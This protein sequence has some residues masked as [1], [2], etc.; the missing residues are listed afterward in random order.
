M[1]ASDPSSLLAQLTA[2]LAEGKLLV[3]TGAGVSTASGIPDY[4][5]EGTRARAR[6]PIQYREF[7]R[8]GE[9]RKRYWARSVL[10]YPRIERALPNVAH[11]ALAS[12]AR[13]GRLAGLVTQNVDGLHARAEHEPHVELHGALREVI[14]IQCGQLGS[15]DRLQEQLVRQNGWL[16]EQQRELAPDGDSELEDPRIATMELV[17][18][19]AC[20]GPLKPHVVFFGEGVPAERVQRAFDMLATAR[21]L[22]VLGSSLAVFSGLRFVRAAHARGLPVGIVTR[23]ATRGDPL[24]SFRI[25]AELGGTLQHALAALGLPG[26]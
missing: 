25:D 2:L 9:A 11:R 14:C 20:G 1:I 26:E 22:L 4:R 5:G 15:R 16:M 19:E 10:G 23:G 6:N 24:A 12:L 3:L 21:A 13:N 17:A 18:C 8:S 7:L